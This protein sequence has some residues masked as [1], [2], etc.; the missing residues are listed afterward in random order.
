MKSD[1]SFAKTHL[2]SQKLIK[3]MKDAKASFMLFTRMF[4]VKQSFA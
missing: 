4:H 1:E 3:N 2:I